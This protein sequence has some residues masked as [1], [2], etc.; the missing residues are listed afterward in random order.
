MSRLAV[1]VGCEHY[2]DDLISDL[3]YADRDATKFVEVS[4]VT[5]P[6]DRFARVTGVKSYIE[7]KP[8]VVDWKEVARA[9]F[10]RLSREMTKGNRSG[11]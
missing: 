1:V 2:E 9:D 3:K 8:V 11:W 4:L 7:P 6:A 10:E 5:F